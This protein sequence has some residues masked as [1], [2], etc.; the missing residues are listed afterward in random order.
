M[1]DRRFEREETRRESHYRG[2]KVFFGLKPSDRLDR[3]ACFAVHIYPNSMNT[4]DLLAN[5]AHSSAY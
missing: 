2:G 4:D 3:E 5:I 1:E